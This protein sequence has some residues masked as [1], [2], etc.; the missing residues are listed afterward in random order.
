MACYEHRSLWVAAPATTIPPTSEQEPPTL[1]AIES[2]RWSPCTSRR[3]C[4]KRD[5]TYLR[6]NLILTLRDP[7]F[8]N[9]AVRERLRGWKDTARELSLA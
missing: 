8:R 4:M 3:R 7:D 9:V 6:V 2:Q 5:A 1:S